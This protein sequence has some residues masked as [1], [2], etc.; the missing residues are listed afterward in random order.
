MVQ[1]IRASGR[2]EKAAVVAMLVEAA[3]ASTEKAAHQSA[4]SMGTSHGK[5]FHD[6]LGTLQAR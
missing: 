2:F 4:K 3:Q 5:A 6:L 1:V